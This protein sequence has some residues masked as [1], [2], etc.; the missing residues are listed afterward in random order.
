MFLGFPYQPVDAA[1]VTQESVGL[2]ILIF[3]TASQGPVGPS[4]PSLLTQLSSESLL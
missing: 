3:L 1:A 2:R 4:H